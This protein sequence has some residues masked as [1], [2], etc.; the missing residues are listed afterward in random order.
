MESKPPLNLINLHILVFK[1][2]LYSNYHREPVL[3]LPQLVNVPYLV[4]KP[5]QRCN[6][7]VLISQGLWTLYEF[8]ITVENNV[9]IVPHRSCTSDIKVTSM[10]IFYYY[11]ILQVANLNY[12]NIY[13]ASVIS[14]LREYRTVQSRP[15]NWISFAR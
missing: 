15:V 14:T 3:N 1:L 13:G 9:W 7:L 6:T 12:I 8:S 2:K 11:T 10:H 5:H 4:G